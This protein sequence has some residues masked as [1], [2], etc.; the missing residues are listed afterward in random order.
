M[1]NA[2][3]V[4]IN[5]KNILSLSLLCFLCPSAHPPTQHHFS[6]SPRLPCS[7]IC[8]WHIQ[9]LYSVSFRCLVPPWQPG[10]YLWTVPMT[11]TTRGEGSQWLMKWGRIIKQNS[12]HLEKLVLCG[13]LLFC[14][15]TLVRTTRRTA[16]SKGSMCILMV[17]SQNDK[18]KGFD[19][20][21]DESVL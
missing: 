4:I 1:S 20:S 10:V 11:G 6:L 5:K 13:S 12:L 3:V 19:Y 18:I 17:N 2:C 16:I 15:F 21:V 9:M 14:Y 7:L 8:L